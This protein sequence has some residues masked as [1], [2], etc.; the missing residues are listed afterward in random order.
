MLCKEL[1]HV[2]IRT[3]DIDK[4]L[5]F[6]VDVLGGRIIRDAKTTTGNGRFVYVQLVDGVIEIIKGKPGADNLGLQH[7]AF[8]ISDDT[9]INEVYQKLTGMGYHYTVVPKLA[10]SG[11]GYL[12]FFEDTSGAIFEMIERKENIRIPGLKNKHLEE[13]DHI[14]VRVT[15]E[16][17]KKCED[18]YLNTLG[19]QVRR[20]LEKP[21]SVMSYYKFGPDTLETLYSV[22][23]PKVDRPLCHIAFRV[24]DCAEMKKYLESQGVE[25]PEPKLSGM[26]DFHVMNVTGPDGEILEFLDRPSLDDYHR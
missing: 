23:K 24:K 6:Y 20:I 19:F 25:C 26:G 13:F 22:G 18:F 21:N 14:S 10:S 8:L 2:A 15:D 11:D 5:H 4:A 12:S 16:S 17:Y 3:G 7:I 1:N 9:N